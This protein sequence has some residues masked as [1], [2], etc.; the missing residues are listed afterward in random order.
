MYE[1][2]RYICKEYIFLLL[3]IFASFNGEA[4]L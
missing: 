1:K 2:K 4:V 3:A